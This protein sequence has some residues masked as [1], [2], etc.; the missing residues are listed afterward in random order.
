MQLHSQQFLVLQL[1]P[2]KKTKQNKKLRCWGQVIS[3][4]SKEQ[5]RG[6][7]TKQVEKES[8]PSE[9]SSPV[10]MQARYLNGYPEVVPIFYP[11]NQELYPHFDL[12]GERTNMY[13]WGSLFFLPKPWSIQPMLLTRTRCW[14]QGSHDTSCAN[15]SII[16]ILPAPHPTLFIVQARLFGISP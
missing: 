3:M 10:C 2:P 6:K 1:S 7:Q 5:T 8:K 4:S 12:K 13:I 15:S 9:P 11:G 16:S 14:E